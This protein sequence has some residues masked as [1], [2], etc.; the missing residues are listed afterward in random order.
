MF[1]I[2][3]EIADQYDNVLQQRAIPEVFRAHYRK[4]LRYFLVFCQKYSP[5]EGRSEQIRLFI[6]KLRT[7]KQTPRQCTQAAHAISLY[8][9]TQP[10]QKSPYSAPVKPIPPTTAHL[11][12]RTKPS[13]HCCFFFGMSS[14]KN[15]VINV[16]CPAPRSQNIFLWFSLDQKSTRLQSIS[17][18]LLILW[19][20]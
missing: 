6:A 17:T 1:S 14:K 20:N 15:S 11:R 12:L 19:S 7:K 13:M 9:E 3:K 10:L 8:F 5:P 4:W 16:T 2:P 18:T